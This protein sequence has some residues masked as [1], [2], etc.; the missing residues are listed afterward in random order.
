MPRAKAST[1]SPAPPRKRKRIAGLKS[2]SPA[3]KLES[4]P[5][6]PTPPTKAP[7]KKPR[8]TKTPTPKPSPKPPSPPLPPLPTP[9]E[10]A[11]WPDQFRTL[12]KLHR[13]L[14][15][16]YTFC[17]TR[18]HLATT[19]TTI[20]T[21]VEAQLHRE[22]TLD[23]IA[24]VKAIA[25]YSVALEW[26]IPD[27]RVLD[28]GSERG[29][30]GKGGR[31][32]QEVEEV[33]TIESGDEVEEKEKPVLLFQFL[34]GDFGKKGEGGYT[35]AQMMAAITM[36]NE[37][38]LHAVAAFLSAH[39][40]PVTSLENLYTSYL[41]SS[42]DGPPTPP[43]IE[44]TIPAKI[45][46]KRKSVLEIIEEIKSTP[47]FY[48]DQIVPG[49]HIVVPATLGVYGSLT[50]PLSQGLVNA[51]YSARNIDV[52]STTQGLYSHQAEAL[53]AIHDGKDV[54]ASTP[55]SSGK[56][57]IYQIPVLAELER[58]RDV[59]A[60]YIFPTKA[61]AQDQLR[62]VRELLGYMGL[63]GSEGW[64]GTLDGDTEMEERRRVREYGRIVFTNPDMLHVGVLPGERAWR[65]FLGRLR[66]VIVDG[67]W[68]RCL[69]FESYPELSVKSCRAPCV[70]KFIWVACCV[71]DAQ[72]E[73]GVRGVGEYG[74]TVHI[75]LSYDI[76]SS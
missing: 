47:G 62:G 71:R 26:V 38:F 44:S 11:Q 56:S 15:I 72:I 39:P 3:I 10:I 20:K 22:I 36:R 8:A 5:P 23:E 19:F 66:F 12:E 21:S 40:D 48:Q 43:A 60:L 29:K 64:V 73:E 31:W 57:L 61:L 49:G 33:F 7:R 50:F 14:N 53:N 68:C 35:Q 6:P 27:G 59:R 37:N 58:D 32:K 9:A 69:R 28:P 18:K 2:E 74:Y 76:E 46:E 34:D 70:W 67:E 1:S 24:K 4:P 13:A 52:T 54:I 25:P 45:P 63:E 17:C 16:I 75:V 55:T 65:G 41:P 42:P 51:L 30:G